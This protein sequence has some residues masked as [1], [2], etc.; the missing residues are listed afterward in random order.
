MA[1]QAVRIVTHSSADLPEGVADQLGITVVPL[2]VR[3]GDDELVDGRDITPEQFWLRCSS[4]PVVP[5]T[6][7]PSP[8]AFAAAYAELAERGASGI[9]SLHIS[10]AL[11]S[12]IQSAEL[13]AKDVAI[14]V[15]VIDTG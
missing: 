2:T 11:S 7:A 3:F 9:A 10:S 6:A 13:A 8:G 5:E 12:T 14:P 15:R 1:V 4:S